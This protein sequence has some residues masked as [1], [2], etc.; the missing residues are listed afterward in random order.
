[1]H[2]GLFTEHPQLR[3]GRL[4]ISDKPGFGIEIDWD[5][6]RK[7]PVTGNEGRAFGS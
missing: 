4:E 7:H 1:M 3:D 5:F 6:V 2:H